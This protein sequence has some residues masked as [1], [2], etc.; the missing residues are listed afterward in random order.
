MKHIEKIVFVVVLLLVAGLF[1]LV[2]TGEPETVEP[3]EDVPQLVGVVEL[4]AYQGLPASTQVQW[5]EPLPQ[6]EEGRWLYR[7]FTPPV[8]YIVDG[9]FDPRPPK[10]PDV[11]VIEEVE[12]EEPFG[13]ALVEL[14]RN[15]YRLQ[16][17]AIY[18]TQLDDIDSA[19]LS[20]EN[21]YASQSER[22]TI[23]M[24][25]GETNE[26][27]EFRVENIEQVE[28]TIGGGLEREHIATI[29]D[30]RTGKTIALSDR[31]DLFE[32][33]VML[34]FESTIDSGQN[35]TVNGVGQTFEMNG[36]TYTV[37]EINLEGRSAQVVKESED[38]EIPK[39][40]TLTLQ[41][42]GSSI[43]SE[44]QVAP[45]PAA[46]PSPTTTPNDFNS[47]FN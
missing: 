3:R 12:P 19:I 1:A 10:P 32:E 33:G 47:L 41:S 16:L 43:T 18:E 14:E 22:P 38:L 20:F 42:P 44:P 27:F 21:V 26:S 28:R 7:V 23:S 29:T 30:L 15:R 25:K 5:P 34:V 39:I 37:S 2:F 9:K 40:E 4:D 45:T 17:K 36:A 11:D 31:E 35:A 46:Q 8:L 24:T 13:V 6:D